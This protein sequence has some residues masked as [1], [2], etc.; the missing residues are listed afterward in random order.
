MKRIAVLTSG[1]DAPGMNAAIRSV[2]RIGFS[3]NIEVIGVRGGFRGL[4]EKNFNP[5]LPRDVSGL[6]E[7]G[8]TVLLTSRT[9]EFKSE[10]IQEKAI[11]N[12]KSE[13]IEGLIVIGGNGS[14]SGNFALSKKDF[15][16][17]GV[18]S[19]IDNDLWGTDYTIGFDT[20]VNNAIQA[21]DK[22]RDVATSHARS[23]IVEVMGR[24]RGFIAIDSAIATG[25]D[26]VLIPEVR[27]DIGKIIKNIKEGMEKKKLHHLIV[28][29]EG[30][31][32]ARDLEQIIKSRLDIEI[33]V[34]VLG[35][36]QRGGSPTRFDRI[37][38]TLFAERALTELIQGGT[39][40]VVGIKDNQ[41]VLIP[42]EDAVTKQKD[43]NSS[44][45]K[46]IEEVSV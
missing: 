19:T 5:L 14:Q 6:L 28:C 8:G 4:I 21:I 18:A 10:E 15:P 20:A 42:A 30:A 45:Y 1:G 27:F 34:S 35:Y 32:H 23:F 17:M 37:I 12:F 39:G 26:I 36:I 46:I 2:V 31:I 9:D 38:A 25:A 11:E 40:K 44:L 3:R 41:I 43:I 22:I 13:H 29:A 33:R 24:D 16:V 7:K